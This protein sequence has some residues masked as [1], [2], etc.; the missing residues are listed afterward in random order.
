MTLTTDTYWD[1]NGTPLHTLAFNIETLSGLTRAPSLRGSD[2]VIP[3]APGER[4][5]P[6]VVG[7]RILPLAMWVRGADDD[8]VVPENRRAEFEANWNQLFK[9]L[10]NPRKQL[11]ITK[12]IWVDGS[13][14]T[15]VAKGQF[16]GGLDPR[17]FGRSA[18][19]FTV[20]I[21]LQYPWFIDT[22]YTTY[23]LV[24]GHQ[25]ITVPG[26]SDTNQ[27]LLTVNGARNEAHITNWTTEDSITVHRNLV[28][29]SR[30]E[31]DVMNWEAWYYPTSGPAQNTSSLIEAAGS[32]PMWMALEAGVNDIEV[33]STSGAGSIQLQ[34]KGV[35]P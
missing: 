32:V 13:L 23:N 33:Q 12:R 16:V 1:V 7:S 5:T 17:M 9:L 27:I 4:F 29:G 30:V 21:K 2:V 20:D 22:T 24:N 28:S 26:V 25:N 10:F 14:R 35:W 18:A 3:Y 15:V 11:T 6:K 34:A 8:G 31:V 19:K